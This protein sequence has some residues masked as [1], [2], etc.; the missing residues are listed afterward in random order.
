MASRKKLRKVE[1]GPVDRPQDAVQ[2]EKP[3]TWPGRKNTRR[4]CNGVVGREHVRETVVPEN[5]FNAHG[6][7]CRLIDR[8]TWHRYERWTPWT[9]SCSHV[10]RCEVCKK[11][12][13]RWLGERCPDFPGWPTDN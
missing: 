11:V 2:P 4:W 9:Y 1:W 3:R 13:E 7:P 8:R 5:A 12:F 10:I 6:A